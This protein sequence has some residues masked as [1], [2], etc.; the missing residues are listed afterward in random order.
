MGWEINL[1]LEIDSNQAEL[2]VSLILKEW[3][4]NLDI[5]PI[6]M[7][8][9]DPIPVQMPDSGPTSE[10]Q[11]ESNA[12]LDSNPTTESHLSDLQSNL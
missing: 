12:T 10:I 11:M 8:G 1:T 5:D 7:Q 2:E 3:E 4:T 6:Q 9:P